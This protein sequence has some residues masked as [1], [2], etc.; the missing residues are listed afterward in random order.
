MKTRWY[1]MSALVSLT[2]G[3][4]FLGLGRPQASAA[5]DSAAL[6]QA[7]SMASEENSMEHPYTAEDPGPWG[8]A[9]AKVHVPWVTYEKMGMGLKV[10]VQIDHHPM[11]P[12]KP[13]FIMWIRLQDGAG[14][15]YGEKTF[16][17]TDAAPATATFELTSAPEMLKAFTRCNIH[18]IW[19]KEVKV[20]M[21]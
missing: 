17:A 4:M 19:L 20:E 21:K 2:C 3:L 13:H 5:S 18:G 14:H 6:V 12:K 15:D 8:E 10:T 16:V 7:T 9:V 1:F 11:D